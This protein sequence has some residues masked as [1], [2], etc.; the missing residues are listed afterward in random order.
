MLIHVV[1][2]ANATMEIIPYL[3]LTEAK[4]TDDRSLNLRSSGDATEHHP[5][6]MSPTNAR[7]IEPSG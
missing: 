2:M 1:M 7:S 4:P 6:E 5:C 3:V